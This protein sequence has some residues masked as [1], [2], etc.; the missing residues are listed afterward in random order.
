MRKN[1]FFE[2]AGT[3]PVINWSCHKIGSDLTGY[4]VPE[5]W[6]ISIISTPGFV[7]R[8]W[9]RTNG[10]FFCTGM[11]SGGEDPAWSV[12]PHPQSCALQSNSNNKIQCDLTNGQY[13]SG[14][15]CCISSTRCSSQSSR[16]LHPCRSGST[17][18]GRSGKGRQRCEWTLHGRSRN[19]IHR[20]Q[21]DGY[22]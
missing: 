2:S 12:S 10:R 14:P 20:R 4:R 3:R 18:R 17:C 15:A 8:T 16:R 11:G 6:S 13:Y 5:R 7:I 19:Y 1:N 21:N 22:I 9:E